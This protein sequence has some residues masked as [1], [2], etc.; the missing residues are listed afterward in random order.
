M[1]VRT[2]HHF[3]VWTAIISSSSF[4]CGSSTVLWDDYHIKRVYQ[5]SVN[6]KEIRV[7]RIVDK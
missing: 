3:I 6:I 1:M 5:Q 4:F 7:V 2:H